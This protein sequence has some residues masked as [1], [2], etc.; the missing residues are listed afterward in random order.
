M[1]KKAMKIAGKT[2]IRPTALNLTSPVRR[3][4]WKS[5]L[6]LITFPEDFLRKSF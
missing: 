5:N 4:K 2:W 6:A 1:F 3:T